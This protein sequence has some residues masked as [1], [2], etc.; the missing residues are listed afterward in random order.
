MSLK[1]SFLYYYML[2]ESKMMKDRNDINWCKD[3]NSDVYCR[4]C[5]DIGAFRIELSGYHVDTPIT[6]K[7]EAIP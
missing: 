7:A 4:L 6:I 5:H 3:Y 2:A 1:F